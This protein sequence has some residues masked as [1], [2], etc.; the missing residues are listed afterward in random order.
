MSTP[1]EMAQ[2][3]LA[4]IASGETIQ[5]RLA[6]AG[7]GAFVAARYRSG[8]IRSRRPVST[9]SLVKALL[10]KGPLA[11]AGLW[12]DVAM[13]LL[14]RK[15]RKVV[16]EHFA[17]RTAPESLLNGCLMIVSDEAAW[18]EQIGL[19]AAEIKR[20]A[21]AAI[22]SSS[23]VLSI[24]ARVGPLPAAPPED[25]AA[26]GTEPGARP[27]TP[28]KMWALIARREA[29]KSIADPELRERVVSWLAKQASLDEMRGAG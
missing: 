20:R 24:K 23:T 17:K 5:E 26:A 21:A 18:A 12:N 2:A 16:G 8:Q 4:A 10:R 29:E 1:A 14:R 9:R 7:R 25:S 13:E 28:H 22:A 27:V 6:K 15:W 3:A 19:H 11:E